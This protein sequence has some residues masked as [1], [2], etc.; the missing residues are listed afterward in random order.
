MFIFMHLQFTYLPSDIDA[1]LSPSDCEVIYSI[2]FDDLTITY[3]ITV[4]DAFSS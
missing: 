2:K 3:V 1:E 4:I